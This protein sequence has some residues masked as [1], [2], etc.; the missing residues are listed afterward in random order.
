MTATATDPTAARPA[1]PSQT[2][3]GR[4]RSAELFG[5]AKLLCESHHKWLNDSNR[6]VPDTIYWDSLEDLFTQFERGDVPAD[7]RKLAG[8]VG[9]MQI[10]L[11]KYDQRKNVAKLDP[12]VEFF[13]AIN[14][15]EAAMNEPTDR[16]PVYA[17]LEK[18]ADLLK[19][20]CTHQQIAIIYE[21]YDE[22]GNVDISRV[23][24]E[25]GQPGSVINE[26]WTDPRIARWR[27]E[28]GRTVQDWQ[29]AQQTKRATAEAINP[30]QKPCHET[31]FELWTQ[32]VNLSQ[33]AAMLQKPIHAV[34]EMFEGFKKAKEDYDAG[35]IATFIPE[36]ERKVALPIKE[37]SFH[38]SLMHDEAHDEAHEKAHE[39]TKAETAATTS[40]NSELPKPDT[41]KST[42]DTIRELAGEGNTATEISKVLGIPLSQVNRTLTK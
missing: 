11:N 6:P 5:A 4:H 29:D 35:K 28:H 37:A 20:G 34:E 10:E 33:S 41:T 21:L 39:S 15:I 12:R 38:P 14:A 26:S 40:R 31:P 32:G 8:T 23:M 7:C 22:R 36:G 2:M 42:A 19:S 18:M 9:R 30:T 25:L 13:E 27:R 16:E 3:P 17:P 1:G 24:M